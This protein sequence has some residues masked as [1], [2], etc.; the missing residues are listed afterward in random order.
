MANHDHGTHGPD[1]HS[2]GGAGCSRA[3]RATRPTGRMCGHMLWSHGISGIE[4][5]REITSSKTSNGAKNVED[6]EHKVEKL[7]NFETLR[8]AHW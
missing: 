4:S 3:A 2:V 5:A 6:S 1:I 8:G 7:G